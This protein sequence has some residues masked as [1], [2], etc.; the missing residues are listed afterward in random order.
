MISF[1]DGKNPYSFR[2]KMGRT[3]SMEEKM[4]GELFISRQSRLFSLIDNMMTV[5][6]PYLYLELA[7]KQ[8][9]FH[10]EKGINWRNESTKIFFQ[11]GAFWFCNTFL[12]SST[13]FVF[14]KIEEI[15]IFVMKRKIISI[16]RTDRAF[17][18][19]SWQH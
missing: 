6:L 5:I 7:C 17:F 14:L 1:L 15:D 8:L 4:N 2:R 13:V 10:P 3:R 18:S 12:K 9:R 16:R 19:E 11:N